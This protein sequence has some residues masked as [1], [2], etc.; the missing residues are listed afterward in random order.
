[1]P[2]KYFFLK[3]NPPR[4]SF[5]ADM[6]P[7]EKNIMR[8]HIAYWQPYV[9][10][11]TVIVMGPVLDPNGG[12]GIAVVRV[13]DDDELISLISKDPANGLNRYEIHP[14]RAVSQMIED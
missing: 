11:G 8:R 4:P 5:T 14:M 7:E 9:L 6:T 2:K 1:M 10:D 3:L 13:A 12:Y